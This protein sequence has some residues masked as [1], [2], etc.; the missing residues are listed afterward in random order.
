MDGHEVARRLREK[1]GLKGACLVAVT[2]WGQPEDRQ[3]SKD[4]GFDRHLLK[5]VGAPL[6]AQLLAEV[7]ARASG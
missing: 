5:P 6:L 4:T 2:G 1:P 7:K 3:R